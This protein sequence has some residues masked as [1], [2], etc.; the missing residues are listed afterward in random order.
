M[1]A[2]SNMQTSYFR[3]GHD[4]PVPLPPKH[5]FGYLADVAPNARRYFATFKASE[6]IRE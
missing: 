4:I 3:Y 5:T 6:T 1:F 2:S